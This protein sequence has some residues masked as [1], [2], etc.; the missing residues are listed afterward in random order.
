M[1]VNLCDRC[2]DVTVNA[3]RCHCAIAAARS[4]A[5][6]GS[7][8]D[9]QRVTPLHEAG[10]AGRPVRRRTLSVRLLS[11]LPKVMVAQVAGTLEE[12]TAGQLADRL[13]ALFGRAVHVVVDLTGTGT[14][15]RG[16]VRAL[17]SLHR[18]AIG[19]GTQLHL[20]LPAAHTAGTGRRLLDRLAADH[21]IQLAPSV[22][23][24]L[25]GLS[26]GPRTT[27]TTA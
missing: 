14:L 26:T 18:E 23:A 10:K 24:V 2:G 11:P 19:R 5:A 21:L 7:I 9:G 22:D 8:P 15:T 6:T 17:L 13:T 16:G 12:T 1:S 4:T 3:E 27:S 25:A 20:T